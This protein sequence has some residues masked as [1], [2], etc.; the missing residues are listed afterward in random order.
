M[1]AWVGE[2]SLPGCRFLM[3]SQG[4]RGDLALWGLFHK[5]TNQHMNHG[6]GG[7]GGKRHKY[8]DHSKIKGIKIGNK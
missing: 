3:S 2:G 1:P 8:S 6:G 4:G 7:M 5:C